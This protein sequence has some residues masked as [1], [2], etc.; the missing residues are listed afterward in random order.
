MTV[1]LQSPS[2]C[3]SPASVNRQHVSVL[4]ILYVVYFSGD[5]DLTTGHFTP[6]AFTKLDRPRE[7]REQKTHRFE[8]ASEEKILTRAVALDVDV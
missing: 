1:P 7:C 4:R 8:I 5:L 2:E 6:V 3:R